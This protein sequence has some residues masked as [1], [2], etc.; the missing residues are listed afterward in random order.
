[1]L[2]GD[3]LAESVH[4]KERVVIDDLAEFGG[5]PPNGAVLARARL[6][7]GD[8]GGCRPS[9]DGRSEPLDPTGVEQRSLCKQQYPIGVVRQGHT[10]FGVRGFFLWPGFYPLDPGIARCRLLGDAPSGGIVANNVQRPWLIIW[11]LTAAICTCI[12]SSASRSASNRTANLR[13]AGLLG[14]AGTSYIARK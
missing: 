12:V 11:N 2:D 10:S 9:S 8:E 4:F 3:C 6:L 1:V 14:G 7:I 5:R 13:K